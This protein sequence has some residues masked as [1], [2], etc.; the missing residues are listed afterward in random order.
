MFRATVERIDVARLLS[1]QQRRILDIGCGG[2]KTPGAIGMDIDPRSGADIIQDLD[3]IPYPFSTD[4]FDEVFGVHVM[5]HV[6]DPL[7]IMAE[8]HRITRDG[9]IVR[10]VVPHWTNPDWATDL[11]HRNCLNSYSFRSLTDSQAPY[12][13]SADVRYRLRSVRVTLLNLWRWLGLEWL[14]NLDHKCQALRFLR[15]FWEHYLN[16]IVR[17][18]EIFFELEVLKGDA[19]DQFSPGEMAG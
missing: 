10:L 18:K 13:F 2:S 15:Q 19:E 12:P 14:V 1:S 8:L 17:G 3:D 16:A 9:G 4:T 5:E 6:R 11:T 7:S